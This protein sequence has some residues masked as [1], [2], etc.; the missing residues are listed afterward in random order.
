VSALAPLERQVDLGTLLPGEGALRLAADIFIP[1]QPRR[2]ATVLFCTPGGAMNR[3]Y[4]DLQAAGA[5][6]EFSFAAHWAARGYFVVTLDPLGIGGSSRPADGYALSPDVLAQA[7]AQATTA[8]R[9]GLSSGQ[10]TGTAYGPLRSIGVGHSMGAMLTVLQQAQH[11]G[12]DALMLFGFGAR[13]LPS[14]LTA[15]EAA[16]ADDAAAIRAN[17]AA[18]ARQRSPEP[19]ARIGPTPQG[20]ELFAGEQADRRAVEALKR[21]RAPLL[22]SAGLFSMI[23]G[24][25]AAECARIDVPLLL[26]LGDRDIAGAPHAIPASFPGSRDITLW[27]LAHTGHCHFLFDS[28]RQLFARAVDWCEDVLARP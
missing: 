4:F 20:K 9:A 26:A 2:P 13:G 27:V 5:A 16:L 14:A 17:L 6:L 28:R 15:A 19:Y 21:A 11:G 24:S 1:P 23:P 12:H 8:V 10:I 3:H 18:L 25:C 7:G 22:V